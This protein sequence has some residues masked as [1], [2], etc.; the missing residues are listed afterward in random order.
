G[1]RPGVREPGTK[2][3]PTAPGEPA[4]PR[5]TRQTPAADASRR[6]PPEAGDALKPAQVALLKKW[7]EEG[8]E[9]TP[10]WAFVTPRRPEPPAVKDGAWVRNPIDRFLLTRLEKEGLRPSAEA[11]LPTL[12]RRLSLDL[13]GLLPL[14]QA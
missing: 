9:Y 11:D 7:I 4:P 5:R 1:R 3:R 13:L 12:I 14:P 6:P 8:A 2:R 10:H